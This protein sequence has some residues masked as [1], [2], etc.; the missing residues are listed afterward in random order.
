MLKNEI[1]GSCG[2]YGREESFIE[3]V[4]G[5]AERERP[6]WMPRHRWENNI[7]MDLQEIAWRGMECIGMDQDVD[8]WL[9]ILSVVMN[10][11]FQ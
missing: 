5:K 10:L 2:M 8:S 7:T 1:D 4:M 9:D 11:W 6:H 3:D